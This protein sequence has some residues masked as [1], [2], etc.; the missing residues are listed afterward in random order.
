V[1]GAV[2]FNGGPQPFIGPRRKGSRWSSGR[3]VRGID[4]SYFGSGKRRGQS[5]APFNG[6]GNRVNVV[7]IQSPTE[8]AAR[9]ARPAVHE[10]YSV[11]QW[12]F[13]STE[14]TTKA[15]FI[16]YAFTYRKRKSARALAGL[17][18]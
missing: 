6:G 5:G 4:A 11:W 16:I 13:C 3:L 15:S 9:G 10:W 2:C 14:K 18:A 1:W 7:A 8:A 17:V 12:R